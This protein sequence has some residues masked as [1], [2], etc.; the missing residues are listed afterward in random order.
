MIHKYK[1]LKI[2]PG[3]HIYIINEKGEGIDGNFEVEISDNSFRFF[4]NSIG[5]SEI[6]NV[7]TLQDIQ[8]SKF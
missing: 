2:N 4:N 7:K 3:D 8:K 1:D 6:V 5:R